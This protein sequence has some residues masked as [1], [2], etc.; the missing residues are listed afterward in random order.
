MVD[1]GRPHQP[2]RPSKGKTIEQEG[3]ACHFR[4]KGFCFTPVCLNINQEHMDLS[5]F[6]DKVTALGSF[7]SIYEPL[8]PNEDNVH[9]RLLHGLIT[10]IWE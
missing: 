4:F 1:P 8:S 3:D 6:M 7:A 5:F 9:V 10:A 2:V